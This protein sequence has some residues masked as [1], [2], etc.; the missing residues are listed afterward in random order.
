MRRKGTIFVSD[1][2]LSSDG[3]LRK[4]IGARIRQPQNLEQFCGP[5]SLPVTSLPNN[6]VKQGFELVAVK[7][8][9]RDRPARILPTGYAQYAY[10]SFACQ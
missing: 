5:K 3:L 8:H 9:V 1:I 10:L 6:V 7:L 4:H 2:N